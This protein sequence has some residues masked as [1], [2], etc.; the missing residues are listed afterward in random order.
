MARFLVHHALALSFFFFFL[1][2]DLRFFSFSLLDWLNPVHM[3]DSVSQLRVCLKLFFCDAEQFA[4]INCFTSI[5]IDDFEET[6][7]C[8]TIILCWIVPLAFIGLHVILHA[9]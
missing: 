1:F 9:L 4:H 7:R 3:G 8:D 2:L 6:F 5:T